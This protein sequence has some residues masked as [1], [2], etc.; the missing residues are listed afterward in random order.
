MK[1]LGWKVKVANYPPLKHLIVVQQSKA[2]P[3]SK[4]HELVKVK[5]MDIV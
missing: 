5:L 3:K 4:W 2:L 1:I